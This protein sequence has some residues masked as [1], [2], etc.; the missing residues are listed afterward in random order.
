M[1]WTAADGAETVHFQRYFVLI[2]AHGILPLSF[3]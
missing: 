3:L 1:C 2:N